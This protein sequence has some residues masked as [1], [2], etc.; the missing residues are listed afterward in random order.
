VGGA[1]I[2]EQ[3]GGEVKI[4]TPLLLSY[5]NPVALCSLHPLLTLYS[6][7]GSTKCEARR[8]RVELPH[9]HCAH[10]VKPVL[11]LLYLLCTQYTFIILS[12]TGFSYYA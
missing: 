10:R 3:R 9:C 6:Y 2:R 4:L 1:G 8:R 7:M 12:A 11:L 5:S